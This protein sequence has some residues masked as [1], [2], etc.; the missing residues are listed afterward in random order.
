MGV[1]LL[2]DPRIE[3]QR[4]TVESIALIR[5][6]VEVRPMKYLIGIHDI[7]TVT[8]EINRPWDAHPG[9]FY[10]DHA[11]M[12]E[13]ENL[14]IGIVPYY[15]HQIDRAAKFVKDLQKLSMFWRR[16]AENKFIAHTY[17]KKPIS[18]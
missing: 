16:S 3:L 4:A 2:Y 1:S 17:F 15:G 11:A 6:A 18:I 5:I 14:A 8:E 9:L 12:L 10:G 13:M 7:L